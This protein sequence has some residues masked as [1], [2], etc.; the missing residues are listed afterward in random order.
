MVLPSGAYLVD[1]HSGRPVPAAGDVEKT[2]VLFLIRC[3]L[4]L[5]KMVVR[6]GIRCFHVLL[7]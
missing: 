4:K 2:L 1:V 5:G 7:I 3:C 6:C